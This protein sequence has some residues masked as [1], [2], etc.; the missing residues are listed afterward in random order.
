MFG[1]EVAND[2]DFFDIARPG[3]DGEVVDCGGDAVTVF[4]GEQD[5]DGHGA[6][7]FENAWVRA[8][9][10]SEDDAGHSFVAIG[11]KASA[12]SKDDVLAISR[13]DQQDASFEI[14][15]CVLGAHC[16][17]H[18]VFNEIVHG[19]GHGQD[20]GLELFA[21]Q[22]YGGIGQN[23]LMR[24]HAQEFEAFA[25]K[26]ASSEVADI[27]HLRPQNFVD[28]DAND[29]DAFLFEK[30]FV[31]ADFVDGPAD[32]TLGHDDDFCAED[33]CDLRVG[34]V[35]NGTDAGM[36]GAFAENEV[37][38]PGNAI[39]GL[40]NFFYER[41]VVGGLQVFAREIRFDGDR[42]HVHE[43]TIE[44]IDTVHENG[45]FINFLFG[46]FDEPLADG[47]DV[48]DSWVMLLERRDEAERGRGLAV[49]LACG[50]N[51]D[52]GRC[53]VHGT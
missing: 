53:G 43:R 9:V 41:F 50:G 5:G 52:A 16:A 35:E 31:Q 36:A 11:V 33:F 26:T 45:V 40:L 19:A 47:F 6:N 14:L 29:F 28:D 23:L 10:S 22:I 21:D 42:T 15:H 34:E 30:S 25:A 37:F 44:L 49:V 24:K 7:D 46:N 13:G 39:K 2:G 8:Q 51:E 3:F 20:F 48:S 18:D 38:F 17:D 1:D 12:G 32:A 27:I 4:A